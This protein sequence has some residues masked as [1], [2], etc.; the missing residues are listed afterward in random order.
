MKRVE[1]DT[2]R[3]TA[4][5]ACAS[6]PW[7]ADLSYA[8]WP[9]RPT[10]FMPGFVKNMKR[11]HAAGWKVTIFSARLSPFDPWTSRRRPPE[12][13]AE[14]VQYVRDMLDRHGLTF[15]DIWPKKPT[16]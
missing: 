12:V 2:P 1:G 11:L 8:M 16:C 5:I 13:V 9:D 15:V 10:E 14:E 4:I 6:R 3:H 7:S